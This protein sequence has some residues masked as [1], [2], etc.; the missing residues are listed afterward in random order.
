MKPGF[1][2]CCA[3]SAA[4]PSSSPVSF[5]GPSLHRH[6]P[7]TEAIAATSLHS[8]AGQRTPIGKVGV[9]L[10][11]SAVVAREL[12]SVLV[13]SRIVNGHRSELAVRHA[14]GPERR[15]RWAAWRPVAAQQPQPSQPQPSQPQP[16]QPQPSQPQPSQPQPSQPQPSQPQPSQ[17]DDQ[18]QASVHVAATDERGS[19]KVSLVSCAM[20]RS[21]TSK[22][23]MPPSGSPSVCGV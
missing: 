4:I 22:R 5:T 13:S 12:T 14:G 23:A 7:T 3:L 21:V 1:F 11:W 16:S 8:E 17:P 9:A 6:P 19:R 10:D 2:S 20:W 18:R 15:R